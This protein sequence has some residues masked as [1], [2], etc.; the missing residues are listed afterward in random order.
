MRP[1][2]YIQIKFGQ[3]IIV[4]TE[5]WPTP[6][7]GTGRAAGSLIKL[8]PCG[9][10]GQFLGTCVGLAEIIEKVK[11][12]SAFIIHGSLCVGADIRHMPRIPFGP[13]RSQ[14]PER[15]IKPAIPQLL[16]HGSMTYKAV[17][18]K[19][20]AAKPTNHVLLPARNEA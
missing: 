10:T 9:L 18:K 13:S 7:G 19:M 14:N 2:L 15:E 1:D 20:T 3:P 16:A 5:L 4:M 11:C 6:G 12:S 8:P 17:C